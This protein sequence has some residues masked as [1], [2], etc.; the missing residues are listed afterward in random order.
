[1]VVLCNDLKLRADTTK[2]IPK[3]KL[4]T[5]VVLWRMQ[6]L[7]VRIGRLVTVDRQTVLVQFERNKV[8]KINKK[9]Q[10]LQ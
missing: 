7:S 8:A 9:Y 5:L 3:S 6:S 4:V 1:M 10:L 2:K